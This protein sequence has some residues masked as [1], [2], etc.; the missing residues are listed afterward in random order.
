[1][2]ENTHDA[3]AEAIAAIRQGDRDRG[4]E[5][6][7][8]V[9]EADPRN[10]TAWSWACDVAE[11]T[12]E[13]IHC[14]KQILALNPSHEAARHYLAQLENGMASSHAAIIED[15]DGNGGT[16]GSRLFLV[17]SWTFPIVLVLIALG[18]LVY[19]RADIMGLLGLAPLDFDSLTISDSYDHF[20]SDDLT[21]RIAYERRESS[22]F[23]GVVRHVYGIRIRQLP[24]LSHDI[25]VTS[26][27]FA[28]PDVVSTSVSSHHFTWRSSSTTDPSG[29]IK[30]LHT[31]PA[32][33]EIYQQLLDIRSWDEV[34]IT[35]REILKIE[36]YDAG[37]NY[38][39]E[40]HDT[41]C[42]SL[43]VQSVTI[44]GE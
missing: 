2:V 44:V 33:E 8:A 23:A 37:G 20:A 31:V 21:W 19:Y 10:E 43:L 4:R 14:L 40:W 41:G 1:M 12:E 36:T 7:L 28:D 16:L 18:I 22:Q 15:E 9:L 6:I 35:G 34:V 5:L 30:L 27:E 24:I 26:G 25:L 13:R 29:R 3:L 17:M 39:G 38:V 11:T 42:N 32:N